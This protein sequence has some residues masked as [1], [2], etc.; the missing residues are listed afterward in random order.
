[1]ITPVDYVRSPPKA[2][3]RVIAKSMIPAT[4]AN[5]ET[6]KHLNSG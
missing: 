6:G 2:D 1:M 5:I 4:V 3:I